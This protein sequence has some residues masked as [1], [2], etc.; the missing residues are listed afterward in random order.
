MN[1]LMTFLPLTV[2]VVNS[3]WLV[4]LLLGKNREE[5]LDFGESFILKDQIWLLGCPRWAM[6]RVLECPYYKYSLMGYKTFGRE[7]MLRERIQVHFILWNI[8]IEIRKL[9]NM[10][11]WL[12]L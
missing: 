2:I 10:R 9:L 4:T 5:C 3:Q 12:I 11:E 7:E 6:D 8:F 1:K